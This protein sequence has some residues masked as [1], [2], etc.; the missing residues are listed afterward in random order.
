MK[1]TLKEADQ[2]FQEKEKISQ[3]SKNSKLAEKSEKIINRL[4]SESE[5]EGINADDILNLFSDPYFKAKGS[6]DV[7]IRNN[8]VIIIAREYIEKKS[9]RQ[10][11]MKIITK[12]NVKGMILPS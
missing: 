9:K 5:K 8:K 12:K 11:P 7:K 1:K 3:N 6:V 4:R 10:E 2:N